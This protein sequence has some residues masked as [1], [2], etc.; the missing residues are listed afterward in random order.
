MNAKNIFNKLV[1]LIP[2]LSFFSNG[3]AQVGRGDSIK[4]NAIAVY[5]SSQAGDR[6]SRKKDAYFTSKT[7]SSAPVIT[8][9]EGKSYQR[10]E[11]FGATFNEAG[12]ICLNSLS[13]IDQTKVFQSLFDSEKGAG[14]S[15]MKSPI[16]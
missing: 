11:G 15:F 12:M 4:F 8:I 5:I 2:Y 9:N 1:F 13:S 3:S 14:F 6:L 10:M 16:A 7:K